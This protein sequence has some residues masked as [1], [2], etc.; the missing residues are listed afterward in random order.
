MPVFDGKKY[1]MEKSEGF[2][3]YMKALGEFKVFNLNVRKTTLIKHE[4]RVLLFSVCFF[5]S[6]LRENL[7]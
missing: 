6:V 3:E 1:K 4:K 2:D 5:P 7:N